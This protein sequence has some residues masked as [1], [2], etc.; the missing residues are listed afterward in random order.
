[1]AKY[2]EAGRFSENL[3][4]DLESAHYHLKKAAGGGVTDALY[5]L[6]HMHQQQPHDDFKDISVEVCVCDTVC[7]PWNRFKCVC[8]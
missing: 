3:T 2:H 7:V 8:T 4:P 5:T 6:A 1:M